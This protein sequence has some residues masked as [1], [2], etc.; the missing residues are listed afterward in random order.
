MKTAQEVVEKIM[1]EA[2][3]NTEHE[4]KTIKEAKIGD[5]IRQGDIYIHFVGKD[6]PKG[7]IRKDHQLAPGFSKGSRHVADKSVEVFDGVRAPESWRKKM[8]ANFPTL[9]IEVMEKELIGP[10][11]HFK[12]R[13]LITHPEHADISIPAGS[14]CQVIYQLNP[15]TMKRSQD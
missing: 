8:Q 13:A 1:A 7:A 9:R 3:V 5:I 12:E 15:R 10:R 6:H 4:L 2:S 14:D 11:L